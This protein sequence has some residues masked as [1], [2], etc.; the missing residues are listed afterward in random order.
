MIRRARALGGRLRARGIG[1]YLAGC[2]ACF[3]LVVMTEELKKVNE[4]RKDRRRLHQK[5]T[6]RTRLLV[7]GKQ[8][9]SSWGYEQFEKQV[10]HTM[11]VFDMIYPIEQPVLEVD[12]SVS[13]AK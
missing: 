9:G 2:A 6:P 10:V 13:H 7:H 4:F 5:K 1:I 12:H 8:K 3:G 11:D